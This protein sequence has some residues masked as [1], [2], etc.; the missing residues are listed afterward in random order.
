MLLRTIGAS[1]LVNPLTGKEVIREGQNCLIP[2]HSLTNFKIQ[3][4]YQNQPK[5]NGIYS[6]NNISKIKDGEYIIILV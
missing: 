4:H 5:I 6:R 1:A 2:F 3:K